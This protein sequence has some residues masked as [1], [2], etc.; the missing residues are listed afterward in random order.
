M[1]V[2]V[3]Q[4]VRLCEPTSTG[5]SQW[6]TS[7]L[8]SFYII[9]WMIIMCCEMS[10]LYIGLLTQLSYLTYVGF[11]N[12]KYSLTLLKIHSFKLKFF[13]LPLSSTDL[14]SLRAVGGAQMVAVVQHEIGLTGCCHC[15]SSGDVGRG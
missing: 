1:E 10:Y 2:R 13:S 5:C 12:T 4:V 7:L 8:Y 11:L 3:F 15:S 6:V 14:L 9:F